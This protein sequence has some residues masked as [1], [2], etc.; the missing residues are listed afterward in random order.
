M[1]FFSKGS[2]SDVLE[3]QCVTCIHEDPG[4]GCPIFYIQ[5]TY[6]YDQVDNDD[7]KEAMN[8]LINEEG[9]C[10]MKPL[11]EKYYKKRPLPL[12][13]QLQMDLFK[14]KSLKS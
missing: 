9:L 7:L 1:A 14:S 5:F 4:T 6:N 11:I 12:P 8:S 3:K 13:D 2:D 10:Q